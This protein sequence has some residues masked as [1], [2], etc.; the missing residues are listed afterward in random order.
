[1]TT[2]VEARA[3]TGGVDTHSEVHVA[4]VIDHLGGVRGVES[5]PVDG[6]GYATLTNWMSAFGEIG[7]VGVEGTGSYGAG[8]ARHLAR[9]GL[10]VVEVDRPN[11]QERAR[12]GKSDPLD[13][14]EAAR[15]AQS[16]RA[17]GAA[18]SRDGDAEAIR[19]LLVA[20]R[21]ASGARVAALNQIR[22]LVYTGPDELRERFVDT[23]S[24]RLAE[25]VGAMRVHADAD[26]VRLAAKTALATL[27]R[28][29]MALGVE[30][31]RLDA[32]IARL[33]DRLAPELVEVAG[34]GYYTAAL[35]L[36]A[37]GDNPHR[38]RTE[39]TWAKLCGVAP[40]AASS[41]KVIRYRLNRGGDRQANHALWIIVASRLS[42]HGPTKAYMARRLAEGKSR[43]EVIRILKRY[44]A[45][46]V[47]PYL[48][49]G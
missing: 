18:K 27:G 41:G 4:A 2:M 13:A 33:V 20:R 48:P 44:V 6:A 22:Q 23:L 3:L 40:L 17:F 16:G 36:V 31:D 21:S 24:W 9:A 5:F 11:R 25:G 10:A 7:L 14:I 8:L 26:V 47:F 37:A 32:Q 30:V 29:A 12:A 34:V 35:L 39:A 46:E 43:R 38:L 1:M 49:R 28:R 45:R 15:A 19:T 42:F